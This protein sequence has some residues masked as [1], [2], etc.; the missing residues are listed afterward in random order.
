MHETNI[1]SI[2]YI[3]D[4]ETKV[5]FLNNEAIAKTIIHLIQAHNE[6]PITIG[7]HGDWG[8]GKSSILEMIKSTLSNAEDETLC[9]KFNGWQFQGFEDAKIAVIEGI[10]TQLID[11]QSLATKAA[12]EVKDIL[13]RI[14]LLKVAKKAGGL[15]LT[16]FTGIPTMESIE[17]IVST[18]K[19]T[20]N[21]MTPEDIA[22][23]T[24]EAAESLSSLIK[25]KK[26]S[27]HVPKEIREFH[28]SFEKLLKK[29]GLNRLVVLVDDLDRCL[30]ET[31]IE[32]LEAIRLFVFLPKTVFIVGADEA[33]IEY[34]VRK[35]FP[36]LPETNNSLGYARNYLEKLIQVPLRIPALGET[37]TEI[38]VSLLLLEGALSQKQDV[39]DKILALGRTALQKP[40]EGKGIEASKIKA[41]LQNDFETIKPLLHVAEQ[42]SPKLSAGTKGNPRQ[43]KRFLN[44][45]SIRLRLAQER[46]FGDAISPDVLGKLML[47]ELFLPQSVFEHIASSV[48]TEPDGECKEVSFLEDLGPKGD[49]TKEATKGEVKAKIDYSATIVED[50]QTREEVMSWVRIQPSFKKRNLKPYLFVI[51]DKKNYLKAVQTMP[52]K[53]RAIFVK[54]IDNEAN[55]MTASKFLDD[56]LPTE[57]GILFEELRKRI[58]SSASMIKQ[59]EGLF[60]IQALVNKH[61]SLQTRYVEL[62]DE[63]PVKQVG[64]WAAK[65]HDRIVTDATTK[66][67]LKKIQEKWAS[68]TSSSA[69]KSALKTGNK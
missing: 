11:K 27:R 45:L 46:G 1:Y 6:K 43:I 4:Q 63:I 3:S 18:V 60:G 21:A 65:G 68:E 33:M 9:L 12:D 15:A 56:L 54:L 42:I 62:L 13:S 22:T 66:I 14:D 23:K 69:L 67:R 39:Y 32:T 41:L 52:E 28:K 30:P 8:A 34:A 5:D 26:E 24:K 40:W 29:S 64:I 37:E 17:T 51:R 16:A 10:V 19:G 58:I 57:T 38:Y 20:I 50:W 7:V 53:L 48:A 25:D 31:A 55:V 44:A 35:H 59:P 61:P 47:A 2:N 49:T 36:D